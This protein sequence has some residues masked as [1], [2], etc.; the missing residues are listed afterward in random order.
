MSQIKVLI[1]LDGTLFAERALDL[2]P[3]LGSLGDLYVRLI[4]AIDEQELDALPQAHD[5]L[6]KEERLLREH[7]ELKRRELEESGMLAGAEVHRGKPA[8]VILDAAD[9][10]KPDY[11]VISSHSRSGIQRWR[12]G[13]VADKVVRGAPCSVI[14]LGPSTVPMRSQ[15][16]NIMVPLDGSTLAEAA[17]PRGVELARGL[18][19]R[20]H[21]VRVATYPLFADDA[22]WAWDAVKSAA[23]AYLESTA[24]RVKTE[25]VVTAIETGTPATQ[26]LEYAQKHHIDLIAMTS[27]GRGGFLRSALGSVTN[28]LLGGRTPVLVIKAGVP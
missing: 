3:A 23:G 4:G 9:R 26:L 14:V 21:L 10:F 28:S 2:L 19:A 7:L 17:L 20:L 22:G 15:V 24:Q 13:S 11:I 25:E 8:K 5:W 27:H 12:L 18:D 16:R 6:E 1:P